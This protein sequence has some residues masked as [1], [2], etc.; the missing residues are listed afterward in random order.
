MEIIM[1]FSAGLLAG[2]GIGAMVR[3]LNHL[4]TPRRLVTAHAQL[5]LIIR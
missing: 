3:L 4:R 1:M 2:T 5:P